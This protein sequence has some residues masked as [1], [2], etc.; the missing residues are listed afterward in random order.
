MTSITVADALGRAAGNLKYS[1]G[2]SRMAS[3]SESIQVWARRKEFIGQ[4]RQRGLADKLQ[5]FYLVDPR[6]PPPGPHTYLH[7]QTWIFDD[8]LAYVGSAN[9]NNRGLSSDSEIAVLVCDKRQTARRLYNFAHG[10]RMQLRREHLVVDL[11]RLQRDRRVVR[12]PS[13]DRVVRPAVRSG[14]REGDPAWQNC[15]SRQS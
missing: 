6:G 1:S 8:D 13:A 3:L 12:Q 4:A 15:L 10:L 9:V 11:G 5:V 7:A 2:S 14:H